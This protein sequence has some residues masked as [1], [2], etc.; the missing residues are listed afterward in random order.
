MTTHLE[1]AVIKKIKAHIIEFPDDKA[2]DVAALFEV[3]PQKV[4]NARETLRRHKM[5]D[6]ASKKR[7]KHPVKTGVLQVHTVE[8]LS[9][10][11][12]HELEHLRGEIVRLNVIISYLEGR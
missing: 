11:I 5:L 2:G 4:Y 7:R 12:Q 6:R 10:Q 1:D 9:P 3:D 8:E